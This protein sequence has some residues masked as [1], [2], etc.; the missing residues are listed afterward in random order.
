MIFSFFF[1]LFFLF[2]LC[3]STHG[4]PN[5]W[6]PPWAKHVNLTSKGRAGTE[7]EEEE[8]A[9]RDDLATDSAGCEHLA[10]ALLQ[11]AAPYL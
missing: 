8:E 4:G 1:F 3:K 7:E 10:A 5:I 11:S 6:T 2:L 9:H